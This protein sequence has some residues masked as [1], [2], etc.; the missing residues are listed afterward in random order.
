MNWGEEVDTAEWGV[1]VCFGQSDLVMAKS[2]V[3]APGLT[4][5]CVCDIPLWMEALSFSGQGKKKSRVRMGI[6]P[7]F[8]SVQIG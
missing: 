4:F 2:G 6:A 1:A 5:L 7:R 8:L 3:P